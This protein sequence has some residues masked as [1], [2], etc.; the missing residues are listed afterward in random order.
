M[1]DVRGR[2]AIDV[3]FWDRTSTEGVQS[4]KTISLQ[5]STEY[6]TGKVAVVSGTVSTAGAFIDSTDLGYRGSDGSVVVIADIDAIAFSATGS[7]ASASVQGGPTIES[8]AGSVSVSS[9]VNQADSV[10]IDVVG[11][12][13][14]ASYTLVIYGT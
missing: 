6:T 7:P 9:L 5:D 11:T 14:T 8:Q 12:S 4:L 3:Q 10:F 13:G 1:S 2:I